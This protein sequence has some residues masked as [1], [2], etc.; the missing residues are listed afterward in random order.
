M[1]EQTTATVD[2]ARPASD[3]AVARVVA[4]ASANN[5][6]AQVFDTGRQALEHLLSVIP[7]GA[8]VFVGQSR[9]LE[10]IGLVSYLREHPGRIFDRRASLLAEADM[11]KRAA[12][13]RSLL[14]CP[15]WIGSV[16]AITEAGQLVAVSHTGGNLAAYLSTAERLILV[17][18]TNKIVPT[19][20]DA[21]RRAREHS[22][23]LED[24]RVKA[25]GLP[26]SFIGKTIIVD[27]ENTPGRARLLLVKESLGF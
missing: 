22:L 19:L 6:A 12:M 21:F 16:H 5:I 26:G 27:R 23:P 17:A 9:T 24:A 4:A 13:R 3:E 10:Q 15:L 14:V 20:D 11:A 2:Y 18:G 25:T 7:E 8:D 1:A